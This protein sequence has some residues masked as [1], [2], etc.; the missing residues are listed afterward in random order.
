MRTRDLRRE[1]C[2][3]RA[4]LTEAD[5]RELQQHGVPLA[6]VATSVG[7]ARVSRILDA[8]HYEPDPNGV[9]AFITPVLIEDPMSP[10]SSS[11]ALYVRFGEIVD[12]LAWDPQTPRKWALR[13]GLATWLGCVPP[14][15]LDPH[16]VRVWRSVLNWLHNDC[17][18][19]VAL[20]RDPAAVYSLLMGFP[21][22]IIAEDHAHKRELRT[23]LERPW[24]VPEVFVGPPLADEAPIATE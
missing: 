13:A 24:P 18:G 3:A 17:T 15:Y 12:L 21:G 9:L 14:Q 1:M 19:I 8:A 4:A 16:P 2:E 10:E 22:G 6:A 23:L 20:S 7:I 11:P 5:V